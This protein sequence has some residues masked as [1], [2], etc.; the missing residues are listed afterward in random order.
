M[1]TQYSRKGEKKKEAKALFEDI[2]KTT[3]I[4]Q[5]PDSRNT[6]NP[7]KISTK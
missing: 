6:M 5:T 2:F 1:Q 7:T 3:K 4:R